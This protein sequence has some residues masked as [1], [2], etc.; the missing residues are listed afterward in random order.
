ML[1]YKLYDFFW[2]CEKCHWYF[3]RDYIESLKNIYFM[4]IYVC[5]HTWMLHVRMFF[6]EA[7]QEYQIP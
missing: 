2:F 1:L 4:C 6:V 5:L 7:R 3:A